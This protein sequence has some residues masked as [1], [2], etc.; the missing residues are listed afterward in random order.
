[1]LGTFLNVVTVPL[2]VIVSPLKFAERITDDR[3]SFTG[4][5]TDTTRYILTA[6]EN[7]KDMDG[8]LDFDTEL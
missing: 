8:F 5:V 3:A 7:H 1:M 4:S 2:R 6:K